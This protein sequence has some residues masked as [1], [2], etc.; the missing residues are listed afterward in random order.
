M[1]GDLIL[2][3]LSSFNPAN[4]KKTQNGNGIQ[5]IYLGNTKYTTMLLLLKG[6]LMIAK[7]FRNVNVRY[8][9]IQ[10]LNKTVLAKC[11]VANYGQNF[12]KSS[13]KN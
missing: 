10:L 13:N 2:V 5:Q 7:P 1:K 9:E 11:S 8:K 12:S 6:R 3:F 4:V